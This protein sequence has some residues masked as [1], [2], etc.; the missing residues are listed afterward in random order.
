[1][2]VKTSSPVASDA[3]SGTRECFMDSLNEGSD[4]DTRVPHE[5]LTS[6]WVGLAE[7]IGRVLAEVQNSGNKLEAVV[8]GGPWNKDFLVVVIIRVNCRITMNGPGGER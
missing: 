6:A 3:I 7:R 4:L 8:T 2:D 5:R 1:V